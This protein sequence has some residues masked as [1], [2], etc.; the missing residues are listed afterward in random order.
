MLKKIARREALLLEY[1]TLPQIAKFRSSLFNSQRDFITENIRLTEERAKVSSGL[2]EFER[3]QHIV[4]FEKMFTNQV[5]LI[6]WDFKK[7]TIYE[8]LTSCEFS[9]W[10]AKSLKDEPEILTSLNPETGALYVAMYFKSPPGRILHK[11]WEGEKNAIPSFT[12]FKGFKPEEKTA[13]RTF[14]NFAEDQF[15]LLGE[16]RTLLM[17][18][19][20]SRVDV[21]ISSIAFKEHPRVIFYKR[22]FIMGLKP[23]FQFDEMT[24]RNLIRKE[25]TTMKPI[26]VEQ[27][28]PID[29]SERDL[30]KNDES[31]IQVDDP[32]E[33]L[34]FDKLFLEAKEH[35]S[36][37]SEMFIELSAGIRVLFETSFTRVDPED[38]EMEKKLCIGKNLASARFLSSMTVSKTDGRCIKIDGN[39]NIVQIASHEENLRSARFFEA[40]GVSLHHG[41]E[42]KE[43]H[44]MISGKGTVTRYFTDGTFEILYPSGNIDIGTKGDH[45]FCLRTD[46]AKELVEPRRG[47][48]KIVETIPIDIGLDP[49]TGIK[50]LSRKD[51]MTRF[52]YPDGSRLVVFAD[53]TRIH[54]SSS[55]N[56]FTIQHPLH[57]EIE[58]V[59]DYFRARNPSIIG[60]GSAYATKGKEN[61][62]ERSYT[63]RIAKVKMES[64]AEISIFK[65]M[66]ELEG[67]NNFRLVL[68]TLLTNPDK[69]VIKLENYGELVFV[70]QRD[71][72]SKTIQEE[73]L[74]WAI[75]ELTSRVNQMQRG[76]I[77]SPKS[78]GPQE[79]SQFDY[80]IQLF[81]PRAERTGGVLSADLNKGEMYLR[82]TESNEFIIN[83]DGRVR[84]DIAVSFN[85]NNQKPKWD[86]KAEYDGSEYV[87]SLNHDLPV[88]KEWQV[89]QLA[90]IDS[91]GRASSFYEP[92]MLTDY[93]EDKLYQC[94]M[95][96]QKSDRATGTNGLSV[97]TLSNKQGKNKARTYGTYTVPSIFKG[98]PRTIAI[99]ETP[100]REEL[101]LRT[102]EEAK[103]FKAE[104][105]LLLEST[106]QK[107]KEWRQ[108]REKEAQNRK[109]FLTS[110]EEK[111]TEFDFQQRLMELAQTQKNIIVHGQTNK[112][113]IANQGNVVFAD[114]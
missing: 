45:Y 114:S 1:V 70:D 6:E 97:L 95:V 76:V 21:R 60:V 34:N 93:F 79:T 66:R 52:I 103:P 49:E 4:H 85:L 74:R 68:V 2:F 15:G 7:R 25:T 58:I 84:S 50:F 89:P 37:S 72:Q 75:D 87:D 90:I 18:S 111:V 53:G 69:K 77:N 28:K 101:I 113:E 98:L 48:R 86:P 107:I 29:G 38:L 100:A 91:E 42:H 65:E 67:Y 22:D 33:T 35:F 23:P 92:S 96:V 56:T 78:L 46:G 88:P 12:T 109:I 36:Y 44:R 112:A 20:C 55:R 17:P 30:T 73:R 16:R 81:L 59:Y 63:G 61:L 19:D 39:G 13:G 82:D 94:A 31:T 14:F 47:E 106:S 24:L 51:N 64:G 27:Q 108:Q 26:F 110:V 40:I 57:A 54:S 105:P 104:D 102:F 10:L 8:K 5:G 71:F 3:L 11:K 99:S 83:K 80:F 41:P 43:T 9:Q 62:F 32:E